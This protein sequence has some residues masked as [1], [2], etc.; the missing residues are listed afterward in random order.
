M[1]L[2]RTLL[3]IV[4]II[5]SAA[6]CYF[7]NGRSCSVSRDEPVCPMMDSKSRNHAVKEGNLLLPTARRT[8]GR[9]ASGL[10]H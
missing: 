5:T 2:D 9:N 8:S 4:T 3:N 1:E 7:G 6:T 10:S